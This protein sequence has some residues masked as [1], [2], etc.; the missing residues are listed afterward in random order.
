MPAGICDGGSMKRLLI[1]ALSAFLAPL[2]LGASERETIQLR[3]VPERDCVFKSKDTEVIFQVDLAGIESRSTRRSPLNLALVLDR[4]G[5][6]EGAKI[7]KAKQAACQA[8]DRLTAQ[9][10]FSLVIFDDQ[11]EV[12]IP[13]QNVEDPEG[14]KKIVHRI[15]ARG[16]TALYGGVKAGAEQLKKFSS[17]HNINRIILLSDGLANVGP[18]SSS[19][20]ARLGRDLRLNGISVSTVGVGDDYNENLMVALAEA[21]A[22]NYYYVKDAEMLPKIFSNELGQI[23]NIIARN[24]KII[25]NLPAGVEPVEV[26]GCPE[27]RFE[28]RRAEFAMGEFYGAQKRCL[29]V[30]CR[31]NDQP[32]D[33][34]RVG[35]VDLVYHNESTGNETRQNAVASVKFT[36]QREES[37]KSL[38]KEVATQSA[39]AK[40]AATRAKALELQDAGKTAEA[41]KLL[42]A[43][44]ADNVADAPVLNSK[45]L[46]SEISSLNNA[47][48]LLDKKGSFDSATRKAFHYENYN[49]AKQKE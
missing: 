5:S 47:A 44:A 19:D 7:E 9:D 35:T 40:N 26:I 22:A 41:A 14:L 16:S 38:N 43:Q 48:D 25:I 29:L 49:Q 24:L 18:S 10:V 23:Q 20:L 28:N 42:R 11:I 21:S 1:S 13:P 17:S 12:L 32:R 37:D 36:D 39:L 4:S 8:I 15:R 31:V 6:M 34:M 45:K 33:E 30:R 3:V 27:I 2:L 46:T